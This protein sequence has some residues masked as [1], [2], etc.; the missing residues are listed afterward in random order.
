MELSGENGEI[1]LTIIGGPIFHGRSTAAAV[2][3][4]DVKQIEMT[5]I[6]VLNQGFKNTKNTYR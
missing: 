1:T 6:K 3:R 5:F 4:H 2:V